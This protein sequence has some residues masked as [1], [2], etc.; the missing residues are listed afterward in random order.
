S[1]PIDSSTR[2]RENLRTQRGGFMK[3]WREDDAF[4][5][6]LAPI[7]FTEERWAAAPAEVDVILEPVNF[8]SERRPTETQ[9]APEA[10]AATPVEQSP[11]I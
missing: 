9:A 6:T 8:P 2:R 10:E 5:H 4:W 3:A 1:L 11:P 7:V